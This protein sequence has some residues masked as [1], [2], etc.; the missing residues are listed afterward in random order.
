MATVQRRYDRI[1]KLVGRIIQDSR[2]GV[3]IILEGA[4]DRAALRALGASGPIICLK[5]SGERVG[6]VLEGIDSRKGAIVLTDFD[7]EGR[8]LAAQVI[9]EF[10]MR[11]ARVNYSI[12]KQLKALGRS[13]IRSIEELE[14]F[15]ERIR[16]AVDR[17]G[18]YFRKR[19]FRSRAKIRS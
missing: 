3:P 15:I 16:S 18:N 17:D 11:K 14:G 7:H 1:S 5:G 4:N 9:E 12:W 2:D 6:T 13:D 8:L 19:R 10:S